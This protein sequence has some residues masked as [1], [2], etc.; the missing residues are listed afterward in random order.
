MLALAGE[1]M[2]KREEI[3]MEAVRDHTG[4]HTQQELYM[5]LMLEVMLDCRDLLVEIETSTDRLDV[6]QDKG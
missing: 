2:R 1:S 6:H 3:A 4:Y 5:A